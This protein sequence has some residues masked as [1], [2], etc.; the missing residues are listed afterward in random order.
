MRSV[1]IFGALSL[2]NA[3][4]EACGSNDEQVLLQAL[5]QAHPQDFR[6][7][8]APSLLLESVQHIARTL[9]TESPEVVI[10]AIDAVNIAL[11]QMLP[12]LEVEHDR[13]QQRIQS[14]LEEI[15]ACHRSAS[16]GASLRDDLAGELAVINACIEDENAAAEAQQ[17][18]CDQWHNHARLMTFPQTNLPGTPSSEHV[19]EIA[20]DLHSWVDAEWATIVS[21]R[22]GCNQATTHATQEL[23]RCSSVIARYDETF[24]QHQMSCHLLT[25]CHDH[26]VEVYDSLVSDN[27]Q[28]MS[29]R[30]AQ[31]RTS[32]QVECILRLLTEAV[33]SNTTIE[34]SSLDNCDG[35]VNVAH[36]ELSFPNPESLSPC[37]QP[38]AGDPQCAEVQLPL[39]WANGEASSIDPAVVQ[40]LG[41]VVDLSEVNVALHKPATSSSF[42]NDYWNSYAKATDGFTCNRIRGGPNCGV[43]HTKN[44]FNAWIDIDLQEDIALSRVVVW[45]AWEHCCRD[46]INPFIVIFSDSAGAEI[47]RTESLR[48]SG[49]VHEAKDISVPTASPVRHVRVQLD[50]HENNLYVAEI[51]AF[52]T[53]KHRA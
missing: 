29:T 14:Q 8:A 31:Y 16:H 34:E 53:S 44:E 13:A 9:T 3:T 52:G 40:D 22:D 7:T 45:N 25:S 26:E 2:A 28:E 42:H 51:Q 33:S 35:N 1:L 50:N 43:L 15:Q 27:G 11:S 23:E 6:R 30:Q 20:E 32:K 5:V 39:A 38:Q 10:N 46:R 17:R 24:C 4:D 36:L 18:E 48:M 41:E 19:Y 37:P 21:Q 49:E 47:A 12:L